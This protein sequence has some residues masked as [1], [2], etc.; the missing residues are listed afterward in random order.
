MF[1][2]MFFVRK[3][4]ELRENHPATWLRFLF[5]Y[6]MG[7]LWL[8]AVAG[9]IIIGNFAPLPQP[10]SDFVSV[11]QAQWHEVWG[12]LYLLEFFL[13]IFMIGLL[14]SIKHTEEMINADEITTML[15]EMVRR[16]SENKQ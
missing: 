14:L 9:M 10:Y 11:A 2:I 12:C 15:K 5:L 16:T 8:S 1:F 4:R 7:A 6:V 13:P 3:L